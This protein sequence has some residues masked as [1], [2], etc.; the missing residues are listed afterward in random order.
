VRLLPSY[1]AHDGIWMSKNGHLAYSKG[2]RPACL[3]EDKKGWL[4]TV[5]HHIARRIG[6]SQEYTRELV[7]FYKKGNQ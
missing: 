6:K 4:E 2:E 5:E 3:I 1:H 7:M